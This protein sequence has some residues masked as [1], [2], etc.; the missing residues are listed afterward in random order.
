[1]KLT[2]LKIGTQLKIAFGLILFLI[3]I[4]GAISWNHS[5]KLAQ[6]TT[7][8]F[9]H[10]HTVRRA[11]G[12]L[13]ADVLIIHRAMKD[14]CLSDSPAEI[15]ENVTTV[16]Q[17]HA[18]ALKQFDILYDR[19][20]G[21]VKDIDL[22][23]K[24]FVAWKAIRDETI[25]LVQEG[26]YSEAIQRTTP[27]GAGGQKV[28]ELLSHIQVIDDFAFNKGNQF[29]NDA[30]KLRRSLNRQLISLVILILGLTVIVVYSLNRTI[31]QPIAELAN[32]TRQFR[33]GKMDI[34]SN[35]I[36]SNEF[37]Q[38]AASFNDLAE[39]IETEMTL[40]IQS[41]RLAGI[42]LSEDDAHR[43]C[44]A[45]L[46][47]LIEHTDAQMG[48]VYFLNDLKSEFECF[49][50]LGMDLE[51]CKPFSAV[52]FE[53][54]FGPALSNQTIQHITNIPEDTRFSFHT[55]SGKFK[56]REIISIPVVSGN[57]T[58]AV[59]SLS[60]IK[61]FSQ[62]SIR[63]L[64]T[65]FS[66][67]SARMGGILAYRK[68]IA[69]SKQLESQ[70]EQLAIQQ[71]E[72][73]EANAYNRS[74][75]EASIDPLVTIGRDGRIMDVNHA[76]ELVTGRTREELIGTDFSGYFSEPE[77]ASSGYQKVFRDGY[78]RDYEL[79]IQNADGKIT[80]VLYNASVYTDPNGQ[81][82]GV[83]AAARDIS[84]RKRAEEEMRILN[85]ELKV[86][87]E[88]LSVANQELQ[89]Q[90]N[91]LSEQ[92]SELTEQNLEL[93]IQKNQL[94][95]VNRLKT[96]FLSNMSH[97]LRTPLNSVIA[98]SGVLNRRLSG[99]VSDEEYG[100]IDII[101][102]NGKQLLALINDILDLSRIEAGRE[103]IELQRFNAMELIR[104]VAELI[105]PQA[106][107]KNIHIQFNPNGERL[108]IE[109]DYNKCRHILQN[110]VANAVKFTEDG[111]VEIYT[112]L[113]DHAMKI[114][115]KDTGI[116]I[117]S[118]QLA[119]IFDEFRQADG[120]SSRKYGGTG[121]GLA[122]AKKYANLLGGT[123]EVES[124]PGAGSVFTLTL[125]LRIASEY[126]SSG[127]QY[128]RQWTGTGTN[129][130]FATP[131]NA[132]QKTILVVE[133]SEA[134][135][136]QL[137]EILSSQ[138]YNILLASNGVEALEQ[139]DSQLPDAMILDL[140][141]PEVDGFE[142]LK[143]IREQPK[144]ERLPVI[145]LT[146]KYVTKEE[147]AF[148]KHNSIHQLIFKGDI[149]KVQLL[150]EVADMMFPEEI[151]PAIEDS[152]ETSGLLGTG[153]ETPVVL[154]VE[155][156]ADNMTTIKALLDDRFRVIEAEDG[157]KGLEM[158]EKHIPDLIL[159]DIALPGINGIEVLKLL[160]KNDKLCHIPVLSVTASAMKTERE[161]FLALGFNGYI[162]KP[163]DNLVFE[164]MISQWVG[165]SPDSKDFNR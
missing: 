28:N 110:L 82:I 45:L 162:S 153:K 11:L 124:E 89:A 128:R 42:M 41:A 24:D 97:E 80:P 27:K 160:R 69:F 70:N 145:I 62:N 51:G 6:Q 91:E 112:S 139:I 60:T 121:L 16:D 129:G 44:H 75:L 98:L 26:N 157:W 36:S 74:L 31:R 53:G 106:R 32:V 43:F 79:A 142:V 10:P 163:I 48:A 159:M 68:M 18:N 21:P 76:T 19:Y 22:A 99:K 141:M 151:K 8:L 114:S 147:L 55:V 103:E 143:R 93:E 30:I 2:N 72:L 130:K 1:M 94:N 146:A 148:F 66:T 156:N 61:S 17:Y 105:E 54:E 116:G 92:A 125:P 47:S 7:D 35:N 138:G 34:R 161:E 102:R 12:E 158:A 33:E 108:E 73:A 131:E 164:K 20:L 150:N 90:R 14:L 39:T 23:S 126:A 154:V 83:F 101:E 37:G 88:S 49:E 113:Q 40:N 135:V 117:A 81:A 63:L 111:L 52:N 67:L 29:Y 104:E 118:D 140:M 25:K 65:I 86:K 155:D 84:E 3:L 5:T 136:I 137:R 122:I 57:E 165:P 50:S 152:P 119:H 15:L 77:K 95:E 46:S 134:A 4:L 59:I 96:I 38:L 85:Q 9:E 120:S 144:T 133:D 109:S 71:N 64:Q 100:Y 56:P 107:Q 127:I 78:V 149:N 132:A 123:I 13:K 115:V 87:S 58:I